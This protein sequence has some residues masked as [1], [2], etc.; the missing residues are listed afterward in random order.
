ME[1]WENALYARHHARGP[2]GASPPWWRPL[3]TFPSSPSPSTVPP[4]GGRGRSSFWHCGTAPKVI[5]H[6]A[7]VVVVVVVVMLCCCCYLLWVSG[8]WWLQWTLYWPEYCWGRHRAGCIDPWSHWMSTPT[9]NLFCQ[10]CVITETIIFPCGNW[11]TAQIQ[12]LDCTKKI[13]SLTPEK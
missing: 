5:I 8:M 1:T 6:C 10:L 2:W 11:P 7:A 13:I 4:P 12:S 9:E 3:L